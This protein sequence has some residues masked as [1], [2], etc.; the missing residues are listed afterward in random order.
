MFA[1]SLIQRV[2]NALKEHCAMKIA[3]FALTIL[4]LLVS[5]LSNS[6]EIYFI[7]QDEHTPCKAKRV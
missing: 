6:N 7:Q 4:R 1:I 3:K 2:K 5:I